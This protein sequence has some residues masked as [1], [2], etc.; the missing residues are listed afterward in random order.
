MSSK[1]TFQSGGKMLWL[2]MLISRCWQA[3]RWRFL[4]VSWKWHYTWQTADLSYRNESS[5]AFLKSLSCGLTGIILFLKLKTLRS[6]QLWRTEDREEERERERTPRRKSG[7]W[8][9]LFWPVEGQAAQVKTSAVGPLLES[10]WIC[11]FSLPLCLTK[12]LP[13]LSC[14]LHYPVFFQV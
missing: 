2:W 3:S 6:I 7:I 10:S 8:S 5:R 11:A 12:S 1:R 4:A 9:R 13:S 14:F